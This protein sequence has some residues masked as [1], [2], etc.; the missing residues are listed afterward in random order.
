VSRQ[1]RSKRVS[2]SKAGRVPVEI[3]SD[4]RRMIR[5]KLSDA[6]EH[7]MQIQIPLSEKVLPPLREGEMVPSV[8]L[9][10][11]TDLKVE[12]SLQLRRVQINQ[13]QQLLYV[14]AS[15]NNFKT[16]E[17]EHTYRAWLLRVYRK[18]K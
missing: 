18:S 9:S 15:I 4:G 1:R 3:F 2:L 8:R 10:L 6:S 5:G 12:M 14:G 13:R 17:Q 16:P 7:G 11:D